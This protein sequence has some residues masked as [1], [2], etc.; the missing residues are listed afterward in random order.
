[1]GPL[2]TY[3]SEEGRQDLRLSGM[4]TYKITK[5]FGEAS[6]RAHHSDLWIIVLSDLK[7]TSIISLKMYIFI[8]F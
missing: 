8:F 7:Y 2:K 6:L 1:M 5:K 4:A 3:Y